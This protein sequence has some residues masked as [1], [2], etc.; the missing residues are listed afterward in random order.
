M[1]TEA[2]ASVAC[3]RRRVPAAFRCRRLPL[4]RHLRPGAGSERTPARGLERPALLCLRVRPR[5]ALRNP[6]NPRPGEPFER[7]APRS[8]ARSR[9]SGAPPTPGDVRRRG[10]VARK[11]RFARTGRRGSA[12]PCSCPRSGHGPGHAPANLRPRPRAAIAAETSIR[13]SRSTLRPHA[14]AD[15]FGDEAAAGAGT[16]V[17]SMPW[18]RRTSSIPRERPRSLLC[19]VFGVRPFAVDVAFTCAAEGDL[20][21]ARWRLRGKATFGNDVRARSISGPPVWAGA[22]RRGVRLDERRR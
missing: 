11:S 14:L 15:R 3:D 9:R 19:D 8:P 10:A 2:T 18:S 20:E 6:G 7:E 13:C 5:A 16:G 1:T 21:Q 4:H 17:E 22:F 12:S